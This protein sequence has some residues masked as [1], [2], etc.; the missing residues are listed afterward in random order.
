MTPL[1]RPTPRRALVEA[2]PT[3]AFIVWHAERTPLPGDGPSLAPR[4]GLTAAHFV[5]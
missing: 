5:P 2:Q 4:M 3:P 1:A